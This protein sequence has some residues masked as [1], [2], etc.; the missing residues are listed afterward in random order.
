MKNKLLT[1][2]FALMASIGIWAQIQASGTCGANLIWTLQ[3]SILTISGTGEMT[4]YSSEEEP[5][6]Y[7]SRDSI[8]NVIIGDSVTSIGSVA[9]CNCG[10]LTSVT[11]PNSVTS[12]EE[13]A[14]Y[15]CFSLTSVTIP[16]SVTI[17][18]EGAFLWC[19]KLAS[20]TLSNSVTS[21]GDN[22]FLGCSGLT[23]IT[24]PN[25]I[26]TIGVKAFSY[27]SGLQTIIVDG[28][29]T[30]YDSRNNCNAIIKTATNTLIVGCQNTIIPNSVTSI[31]E[32]A[33]DGCSGL[34][35]LTIPNSVT[36]IGEWA[37]ND[38][39]GLKSVTI[40]NSVT[41]IGMLAFDECSGLTRIT[42]EAATPPACGWNAF[43]GVDRSIPL[44]VPA[45]SVPAYQT[46]D[47]WEEFTNIVAITGTGTGIEDV[48]ALHIPQKF[49]LDGQLRILLP[50]GTRFDATGRKVK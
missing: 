35:F 41:S 19:T 39:S 46:A 7:S 44:Y 10:K 9:F 16:D 25:N 42:C 12:I 24:I 17:I 21:I 48:D 50:D 15:W 8:K 28:D 33:F 13:Y 14:F 45:E 6:W 11:I 26:T 49:L 47:E 37:F 32:R 23:S 3:D 36:S 4:N 30:M 34:G 20:I 1:L 22:V 29:N 18:G 43:V 27:C 38:C 5:P 40:P 31:G 2:F